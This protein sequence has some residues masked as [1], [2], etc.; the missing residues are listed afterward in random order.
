MA[1]ADPG[2]GFGGYIRALMRAVI[3]SLALSCALPGVAQLSIGGQPNGWGE[4]LSAR[5]V[6]P[7]AALHRPDTTGLLQE[8]TPGGFRYGVQRFI[9]VDVLSSGQWDDLPGGDRMCRLVLRSPG[10]TL[11]SV[12]FDRWELPEGATVFLYD[13]ART[14]FIGGFDRSNEAPDGT[15]ATAIIPGD[16]VVIEYHVP[17]QA[18]PGALRVASI[19]HGLRDLFSA[20]AGDPAR[21][22]DPGYQSSACQINI[23][24]PVASNWQVQKRSTLMFL[25]PD[26]GGCSGNLLNNTQTPGRPYFNAARHCYVNTQSQWVFYFNYEAPACVGSVGPTTQTL[27]GATLRAEF[28][29]DDML[30]VE[31]LNTPPAAYNPYY[32]G[33]DRSG[34]IPQNTTVIEH[35]LY[36][37]KKIAFNNDPCTQA[38]DP[39]GVQMW[40]QRWDNGIVEAV[41]SGSAIFDQNK[42]VVGHIYDGAMTCANATT[43]DSD[44]AKLSASWDGTSAAT[45]LRDWLDPA[46][47]TMQLDGYDPIAV[48]VVKVRLKAFLEGPFNTG[49][50]VMNATLRTAGPVPTTEPYS[51]LGYA[52]VGGGGETTTPAV[53]AVSTSNAVVDWVV[54][55]LRNS[56]NSSQILASRAALLQSDG[57]IVAASDGTSDVSFTGLAAGQYFIAVRHR[58]HLGIMTATVASLSATA[59]L[60]DLSNGS[61]S[62]FGGA[63]ATKTLGGKAVMFAGDVDRNGVLRYTGQNNDRDPILARIGGSVPTGTASGY[64]SEDVDLNGIVRYTGSAND[65]DPILSN[66]GGSVPTGS[67][68]ASLP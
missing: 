57:D 33:W 62:L 16:A 5:A 60:I 51:G 40:R 14:F 31:L 35:P 64:Y 38:V 48:P 22:Y 56:A 34:A 10:A 45:R 61:V 66:V 41:G 44:C 3:F 11:L 39:I 49:T 21:D 53:L 27:T 25:R 30:L 18:D 50:G 55:E 8:E 26:G 52:F 23:N 37:V 17:Y 43:I 2:S 13:E 68:S 6:L 19:T 47:T 46:N 9:D 20:H 7:E 15:M 28:T 36:D 59:S 65:R 1:L 42:R 24:C 12:Q 67:R 58:N 29:W 54:L 4:T 32:A 63:T